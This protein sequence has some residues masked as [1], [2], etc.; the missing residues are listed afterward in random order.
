MVSAVK[1]FKK[2]SPNGKVTAYLSRRDFVDHITHTAPVDGVVVVDDEYLRGRRIFARVAVS[3]R[4][5]RPEDE[6][7]GLSFFKEFQLVNTPVS[8]QESE[9]DLSDIQQ[10]LLKNF[11]ANA[12]PFS[13]NLPHHAPCSVFLDSGND[14]TSQPLGVTYELRL[15]VAEKKEERPH[16]RNSVSFA[17]RR[18]QFAPLE[19]TSRR[20]HTLVSRGF[21]LSSGR[22]NLELSLSREIYQHGQ[23]I[24]AQVCVNNGSK[25]TV[26]NINVE[27]IQHVEVTMISRQFNRVVASL[28]S[29]EGC[30][31]TPG[32]SFT[33]TFIITPLVSSNK[34]RF[35]IA[36]E[37]HIKD[38]DVNLASSTLVPMGKSSN[39]ALGIIVSYSVKVKL[40][41]G[42]IGGELCADL[43]FKLMHPNPAAQKFPVRR[44]RS[45]DKIEFEEFA[46]LR[47]S[48]S[49]ADD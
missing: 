1:V 45:I 30:P 19:V 26:K 24:E 31:I 27:V 48:Y 11:G 18:V 39:D 33:K 9:S 25:K 34:K 40:S 8:F 42:A 2:S 14:D 6:V 28:E 35:G 32:D 46:R 5:G 38:Q 47:R 13:I 4:Y 21:T 44:A 23:S 15:Y 43:P 37:G 16:K 49:L 3:Y 17:V 20:P 12:H 29:K 10:R 41:C 36:F 22:L 7:M